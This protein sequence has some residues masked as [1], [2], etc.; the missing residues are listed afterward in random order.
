MVRNDA[1]NAA[2]QLLK[3]RERSEKELTSRLR[4]KGFEADEVTA[5][6]DRCREYG[7][8]DD[9]RFA[10]CKARQLLTNGRAVGR[11]LQRELQLA[12]VA[13]ELVEQTLAELQSDF[14]E[15]T[16]LD[17]L[18]ERR[19]ASFDYRLADDRERRRVVNYF[20]RRGFALATILEQLKKPCGG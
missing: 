18:L 12:G 4:R 5:A 13:E 11:R 2:V 6:V 16:L 1:F 7:Y 17:E 20:L 8:V 3:T 15:E 9:S 14:K 19:F 10:R